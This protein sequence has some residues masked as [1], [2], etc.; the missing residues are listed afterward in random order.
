MMGETMAEDQ[1][2]TATCPDCGQVVRFPTG[3]G[4]I[5]F[6]CP[7]CRAA[8][9]W[10]PDGRHIPRDVE[11]EPA[12]APAT[13]TTASF[14]EAVKASLPQALEPPAPAGKAQGDGDGGAV[15]H[16]P[17][18]LALVHVAACLAAAYGAFWA[19]KNAGDN[20]LLVLAFMTGL[21]LTYYFAFRAIRIATRMGPGGSI[22]LLLALQ[23]TLP[24]AMPYFKGLD[25][26]G[27]VNI[28]TLTDIG[29]GP[30]LEGTSFEGR[31]ADNTTPSE[32]DR[33]MEEWE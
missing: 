2:I 16:P 30:S 1:K 28:G 20:V 32:M 10:S 31:N 21:C 17:R 11:P 4:H 27:L 15:H 13:D 33:L 23:V 19:D 12:S 24:F 14:Y 6:A 29:G 26:G 7:A 22:G 25:V 18:L 5:R 3:R 9:E 8:L